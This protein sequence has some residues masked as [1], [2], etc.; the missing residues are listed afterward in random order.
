MIMKRK[1]RFK[2]KKKTN[3]MYHNFWFNNLIETCVLRTIPSIG[4]WFKDLNHTNNLINIYLQ[5]EPKIKYIFSK[6]FN[7]ML[8]GVMLS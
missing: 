6:I 2:R 8:N 1:C 3:T 5:S 7:L 4:Y